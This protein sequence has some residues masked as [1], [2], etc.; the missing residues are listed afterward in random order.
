MPERQ[1]HPPA[2]EP[3]HQRHRAPLIAVPDNPP[4]TPGAIDHARQQSPAPAS[5]PTANDTDQRHQTTPPATANDTDPGGRP[6]AGPGAPRAGDPSRAEIHHHNG[7]RGPGGKSTTTTA[8]PDP[9]APE[10]THH[11]GT[12][13]ATWTLTR[14]ARNLFAC[15]W[16]ASRIDGI[17]GPVSAPLARTLLERP[18]DLLRLEYRSVRPNDP[19]NKPEW[20][21]ADVLMVHGPMP[22]GA[23]PKRP[24]RPGPKHRAVSQ[25]LNANR[26]NPEGLDPNPPS[27]S[28]PIGDGTHHNGTTQGLDTIPDQE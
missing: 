8:R 20:R 9:R 21:G 2:I 17:N 12:A 22:Q 14:H 15:R 19:E 11:D 1:T 26:L 4:P 10:G 24:K 28:L 25:G 13:R 6:L 23:T 3:D 27:G 18:D 7:T 16:R 5:N